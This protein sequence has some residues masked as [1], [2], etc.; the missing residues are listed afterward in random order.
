MMQ[1]GMQAAQGGAQRW[2]ETAQRL[3]EQIQRQQQLSQQVNEELTNTYLQLL[4]TRGSYAAQL[5][6]Q[7]Q[8]NFQQL[9]QQWTQQVQQQQR[10]VQQQVQQQQQ[11][12]RQM[13]QQVMS[14]YSQMLNIP[15]SHAGEEQQ[16]VQESA[17]V[18]QRA[19][20]EVPIEGYDEMSVSDI[21]ERLD[22]LS[23]EEVGRVR[24]YEAQNK[25]RSSLL[26]QIDRKAGGDS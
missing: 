3:G 7:Q 8:Q 24:A 1:Q 10:T 16:I 18:V 22:G 5:P 23:G 15:T 2:L 26:A 25:N 21:V 9:A 17:E 14:T 19:T 6:Q 4:N 13:M 20:S 12:F 11:G